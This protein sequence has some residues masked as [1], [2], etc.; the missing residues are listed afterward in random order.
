MQ[1]I[2]KQKP[3]LTKKN[4]QFPWRL[5]LKVLLM[6][7]SIFGAYLYGSFNPIQEILPIEI[8]QTNESISIELKLK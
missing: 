5:V 4:G 7:G 1:K 3:Q 8:K 6:S 2:I